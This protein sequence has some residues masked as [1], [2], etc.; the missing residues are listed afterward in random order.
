MKKQVGLWID[1]RDA[2]IVI[3]GADPNGPG[4]ADVAEKVLSGME[5]HVRFSGTS[6]ERGSAEDQRDRQFESHLNKYYDD[7]IAHLHNADAIFIF[8]PGEAKGELKK[9]LLDSGLS[10]P[11]VVV[12]TADK[13]TDHQIAEKVREHFK[14]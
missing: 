5:K 14:A 9:R 10:D 7:V 13:L 4:R 11:T 3:L 1:H 8:G 6:A 12:E 2:K